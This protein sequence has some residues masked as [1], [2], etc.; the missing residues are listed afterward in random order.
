[1]GGGAGRV[2]S[3]LGWADGEIG[4]R[5]WGFGGRCCGCWWRDEHVQHCRGYAL[6]LLHFILWLLLLFVKL[7]RCPV[8]Q[9]DSRFRLGVALLR[10]A[11]QQ[12]EPLMNLVLIPC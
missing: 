7:S 2:A 12:E 4:E 8:L 11:T 10:I 6:M 1:M 9:E 5:E 3:Y